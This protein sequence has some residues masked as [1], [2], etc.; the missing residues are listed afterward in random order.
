MSKIVIMG[1]GSIVFSRGLIANI[2][3]T[4]E[5]QGSTVA[6][7]D[8][9]AEALDLITQLAKS[10]ARHAGADVNIESS[11]DRRELLPNADYVI[12][13]IAIGGKSAWE[14]DLDIPKKYGIIQPVGDSVGPGGISRAFRLLPVVVDIC[15]DMEKLCPDAWLLNYSNP[16]SCVVTAAHQYS[17]IK[18]IGLCHGLLGT[19]HALANY[20]G[21]PFGETRVLA[22]GVNHLNWILDFRV[23]DQDGLQMVR[24]KMQKGGPENDPFKVTFMLFDIYGAIPAPGDRHVAEF[25]PH[26]LNQAADYGKKY[27]LGLMRAYGQDQEYWAKIKQDVEEDTNIDQ[28]LR[29]SG[30]E[31]IDII[32]TMEGLESKVFDAI[33]LPNYGFV[34]NLPEGAILE[35]PAVV[36][37]FGIRGMSIGALPSGIASVL[38]GI[39]R[40]QQLTVDAAMTGDRNLAVQA[41]LA[42]P[43]VS[44]VEIAKAML[45]ELIEAHAKHLPQ[46]KS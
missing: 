27:G 20:L 26:F 6:L 45:D 1:A 44:S 9:D 28:Y 35:V 25:F 23:G 36:G 2:I 46:F 5:L 14:K 32:V 34:T 33:N 37:P 12:Q 24:E 43:M 10:M 3:L 7:C 8:I 21:V 22:A 15:R 17:K 19:Q 16:N 11:T 13:T 4:E 30:E 40:L 39:I 41:M 38:S 42:D 29:K 18:V 31:V